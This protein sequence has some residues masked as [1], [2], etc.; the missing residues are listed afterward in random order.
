MKRYFKPK[1]VTWWSSL[2]PIILGLIVAFEPLFP[3]PILSE[4]VFNLTGGISPAMLINMGLV[5]V[6]IRGAIK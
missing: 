3:N 5:G 4:I 1:S 6:G 2:V